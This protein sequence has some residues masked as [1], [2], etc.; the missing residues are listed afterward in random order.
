MLNLARDHIRQVSTLPRTGNSPEDCAYNYGMVVGY[1]HCL[2]VMEA[3][4]EP[5]ADTNELV[6]D[7]SETNSNTPNEDK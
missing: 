2:A 4:S 7:F 3:M 6:S 5:L 1:W